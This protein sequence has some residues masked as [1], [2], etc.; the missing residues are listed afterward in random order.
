MT[1]SA[2]SGDG[3]YRCPYPDCDWTPS[4]PLDSDNGLTQ[5]VVQRELETHRQRHQ[6]EL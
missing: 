2:T 6:E 5:A 1:D 3:G 4:R